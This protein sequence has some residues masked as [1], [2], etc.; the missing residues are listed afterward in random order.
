MQ[1]P[2]MTRFVWRPRSR[3]EKVRTL[4]SGSSRSTEVFILL[5]PFLLLPDNFFMIFFCFSHWKTKVKVVCTG[6]ACWQCHSAWVSDL[7]KHAFFRG[8]GVF[9]ADFPAYLEKCVYEIDL[10]GYMW[11]K[12]AV[13]F[14]WWE[15]E[16]NFR[17][18][19]SGR[20]G[21]DGLVCTKTWS[22]PGWRLYC[23]RLASPTP[24]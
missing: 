12:N 5:T 22:A 14:D 4:H 10:A 2:V 16:M 11:T 13:T 9:F 7:A 24:C 15:V 1:L 19:G 23:H 8:F 3:H 21:A 18:S 20:V 17:V 6:G